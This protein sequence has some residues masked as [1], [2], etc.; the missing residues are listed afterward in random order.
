MADD[1]PKPAT[2]FKKFRFLG[3]RWRF[4]KNDIQQEM[5]PGFK[6]VSVDKMNLNT[7]FMTHEN[8]SFLRDIGNEAEDEQNTNDTKLP[9]SKKKVKK[10]NT[11]QR[12]DL[13]FLPP[14]QIS[15]QDR[16]LVQLRNA[17]LFHRNNMYPAELPV[18]EAITEGSPRAAA[19]VSPRAFAAGSTSFSTADC[20]DSIRGPEVASI[21]PSR[22]AS[23]MRSS[24]RRPVPTKREVV[25]KNMRS[26]NKRKGK[27]AVVELEDLEIGRCFKAY[28]VEKGHRIPMCLAAAGG[29]GADKA[30]PA[31]SPIKGRLEPDSGQGML[32]MMSVLPSAPSAT[33]MFPSRPRS[34]G[35][36]V[37]TPDENK[38]NN[39]NSTNMT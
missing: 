22:P 5:F 27:K 9:K 29:G 24:K 8:T 21:V 1:R 37:S 33:A 7:S 31:V 15:E 19:P 34:R 35:A 32:S 26:P 6:R 3:Q 12:T 17:Q 13:D 30:A 16:L 18:E 25:D 38:I 39:N 36:T 11:T 20:R 10:K 2:V 28:S 4:L 23:E 14:E